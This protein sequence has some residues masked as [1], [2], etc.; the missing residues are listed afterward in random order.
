MKLVGM[1]RSWA[2]NNKEISNNMTTKTKLQK[3]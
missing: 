2:L 1:Y 3:R